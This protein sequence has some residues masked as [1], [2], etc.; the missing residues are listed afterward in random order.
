MEIVDYCVVARF[1]FPIRNRQSAIKG[2]AFLAPWSFGRDSSARLRRYWCV[3]AVR[4]RLAWLGGIRISFAASVGPRIT[5]PL[6][7]NAW[8]NAPT[9]VD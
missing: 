2:V 6:E 4:S 3:V 5:A 1:L 9:A 7:Q 8:G